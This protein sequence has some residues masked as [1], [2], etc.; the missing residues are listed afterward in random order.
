MTKETIYISIVIL[1]MVGLG[2][3]GLLIGRS[4]KD[5]DDWVAASQSLGIIPLSGTYFATIV[6]ATSIVSYTG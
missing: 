2:V 1:F 6:S 5:P 4:I 3:L